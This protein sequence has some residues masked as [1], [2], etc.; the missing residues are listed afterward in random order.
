M[1]FLR[2]IYIIIF[3]LVLHQTTL[4]QVRLDEVDTTKIELPSIIKYLHRQTDRGIETFADIQPSIEPGQSIDNYHI[5]DREFLIKDSID[6]VWDIYVNSG[7]QRAW[8]TRKIHYGFSYS[9][10]DDHIYYK[11]DP[12]GGVIPGLIVY[13]NLDLLF[14][15]K[16]LAM[17]FEVTRVDPENKVI[18]FS[19][20]KGNETEGKQQLIFESTP[21]GNTLIAHLSY[22]QSR[23][24]TRD[25][26]YPHV[27]ATIIN[28]F[29]RNMKRIYKEKTED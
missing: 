26:V 27:H 11:N 8:S 28:R 14:G 17:A 4:A 25:K 29:H 19:Y 10:D 16:N 2:S 23:I 1:R 13:L 7:L 6:R 18:E 15:V 9:R 12:V 24:K 21:K 22:Y 3:S 20:L 5:I